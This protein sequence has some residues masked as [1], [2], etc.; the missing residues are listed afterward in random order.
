[1]LVPEKARVPA[2]EKAQVPVPEKVPVPVQATERAQELVCRLR[3]HRSNCSRHHHMP[4]GTRQ[5]Q[6]KRKSGPNGLF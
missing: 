4:P 1:M 5:R 3:Q 6:G 2:Q